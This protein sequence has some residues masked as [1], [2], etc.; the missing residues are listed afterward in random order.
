M[1]NADGSVN[2]IRRF[3][4]MCGRIFMYE[5]S[6]L[7]YTSPI[8]IDGITAVARIA[9]K[10]ETAVA[11]EIFD[12]STTK[13]I[14]VF[15]VRHSASSTGPIT[16]AYLNL[17]SR[18]SSDIPGVRLLLIT[19]DGDLHLYRNSL[20]KV[21][22]ETLSPIPIEAEWTRE[23]SLA[24]IVSAE[25]VELPEKKMWTQDVDELD[26]HGDE[27]YTVSP[28]VRYLRRVR[29]HTTELLQLVSNPTSLIQ[30][31][32]STMSSKSNVKSEIHLFRD[33]FG[34]R[35]LL[36]FLSKSGKLIAVE[37]NSAKV[38]WSKWLGMG[39]RAVNNDRNDVDRATMKKLLQLRS[40]VVK[41]PPVIAAVVEEKSKNG[42]ATIAYRLDAL[43]G[44]LLDFDGVGAGLAKFSTAITQINKM[45]FDEGV[46]KLH[47]YAFV[48]EDKKVY[49]Y[50]DT[51]ET[52]KQ[53]AQAK[54][55]LHF[56]QIK[57][58]SSTAVTGFRL[59]LD[60]STSGSLIDTWNFQLR[61]GEKL[62]GA[63]Q[64]PA[65]D[66]V[67][68]LGRV[69]GNRSVLYK[70]L[71]PNLITIATSSGSTLN[72]YLLDSASGSILYSVQH[73]NTD[74]STY[75]IQIVQAD[76]WV[77]YIYWRNPGKGGKG[78]KGFV[79]TVLELFESDVPDVR[80]ESNTFSSFSTLRPSVLSQSY[81]FPHAV[82]SVG[83]TTT[84]NG[85]STRDLLFSVNSNQIL[86]MPK[87]FLD[88][89]RPIGTPSADDKEEMLIPYQPVLPDDP[90][91]IISYTLE[92]LGTTTILTTPAILESTSMVL[93]YGLD[94]FFTRQTPSGSFD[95]LSEDFGKSSVFVAMV[96]LF[97]GCL[98]GSKMLKRK[99]LYANWA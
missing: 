30:S 56:Y 79:A 52:Q 44:E 54:G 78:T 61:E 32:L 1:V 66:K 87:R 26:E 70:Y 18:K 94:L 6:L 97:F 82:N 89:R 24:E 4:E 33:D 99:K 91:M 59:P 48:D 42:A 41:Y 13:D 69:L 35:K 76:H 9:K 88:P 46:E 27:I 98:A 8:E 74:T 67:A 39:H 2:V 21:F 57:A 53:F 23:E 75:P 64:R 68:S 10:N 17:F 19:A 34:F 84:R 20:P 62:V 51:A 12:I 28:L 14:A 71:N 15:T 65:N 90:K 47:V 55:S 25:F 49:L 29:K 16:Q 60:N 77:V 92:V 85:I 11:I 80:V 83:V 22:D 86:A 50:P 58:K 45:P 81:I 31:L 96:A 72:I 7:M 36:L 93:T 63:G 38:V 37:S 73:H 5:C 3:D 40:A 95:V 43:T